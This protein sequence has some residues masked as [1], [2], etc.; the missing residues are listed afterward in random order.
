M[1]NSTLQL[2]FRG[3]VR[4]EATLPTSPEFSVELSEHPGYGAVITN[5]AD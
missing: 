1:T 5:C 3:Q 2:I 4:G